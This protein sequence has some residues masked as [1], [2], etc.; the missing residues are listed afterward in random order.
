VKQ[1]SEASVLSPP[2]SIAMPCTIRGK[3]YSPESKRLKLKLEA[4]RAICGDKKSTTLAIGT[5]ASLSV[6]H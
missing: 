1:I 2:I 3:S 4:L 5:T 6:K